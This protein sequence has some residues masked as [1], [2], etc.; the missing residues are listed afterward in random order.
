MD[1]IEIG[2]YVQT[3]QGAG[4]VVSFEELSVSKRYGVEL[5]DSPH[6]F[7]PAFFWRKDVHFV[8]LKHVQPELAV[9][10]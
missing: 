9:A 5:D 1:V 10:Q 6:L 8:I 3:S 7:S 2:D 4:T